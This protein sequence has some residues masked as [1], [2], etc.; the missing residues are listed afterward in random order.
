MRRCCLFVPLLTGRLVRDYAWNDRLF[1]RGSFMVLDVIGTNQ[2]PNHWPDPLAFEPAR[3]LDREP[4]AYEYVPHGGGDPAQGH[5]CPGE[6]L[7]VG[8]LEVTARELARTDYA[9]ASESRS[10][11]LR[12]VPSLPPRGVELRD[13]HRTNAPAGRT[14]ERHTGGRFLRRQERASWPTSKRS[15]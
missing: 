11:P 3:F 9:L 5:R 15:S 7:A 1:R 14:D 8:I 6:P 4:N 2:D 12:R 13:V 10:V